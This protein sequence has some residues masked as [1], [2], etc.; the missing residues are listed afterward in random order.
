[1]IVVSSHNRIDLLNHIISN[2]ENINL[3]GHS[4]T[5][6]DTCSD[7]KNYVNHFNELKNSK[8]NFNFERLDA[9]NWHVGAYLH[10]YNKFTEEKKFIFIQDSLTIKNPNLIVQWDS[11]IDEFDV[12]PWIN[13]R[14]WY[15]NDEQKKYGESNLSFNSTPKDSIFGPIFGIRRENIDKIPKDW[16]MLPTNRLEACAFE[17]RLSLIF[18]ILGFSKKYI[19]YEEGNY[20]VHRIKN[21]ISK[22]FFERK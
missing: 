5:I 14:Y 2:L 12:V 6:V 19:D 1:M 9:K 8:I 20:A 18:H 15:E 13:F 21:N 4:V 16:I 7:D 3:N 22:M 11:L 10:S 17:R